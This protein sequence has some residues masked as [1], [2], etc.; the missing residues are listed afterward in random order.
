MT[1]KPICIPIMSQHLRG[2]HEQPFRC[3][4][5]ERPARDGVGL[6]AS[7][8]RQDRLLALAVRQAD[9]RLVLEADVEER[10]LEDDHQD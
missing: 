10:E 1:A 4:Q 2:K 7:L 6:D 9:A 5:V 8:G 3:S